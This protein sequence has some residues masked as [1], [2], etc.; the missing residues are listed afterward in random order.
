MKGL[1][2][3]YYDLDGIRRRLVRLTE[4]ERIPT[5]IGNELV[6]EI[7]ATQSKVETLIMGEVGENGKS[8]VSG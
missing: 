3:V 6:N 1:D 7:L 4:M 5:V 2:Q 8:K